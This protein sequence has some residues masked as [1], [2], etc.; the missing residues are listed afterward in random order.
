MPNYQ[1]A[2]IYK[3]TSKQTHKVYVGST[4]QPLQIRLLGHKA[5]Y[6]RYLFKQRYRTTSC[7][8]IIYDDCIIE[9]IENYPCNNKKE[10]SLREGYY[11]LNTEHT[12]NKQVAGQTKQEYNERNKDKIKE[13][14]KVYYYSEKNTIKR[15][16]YYQK[17]KEKNQIKQREYQIKN[18]LD[19]NTS[20]RLR[21]VYQ[22]TF[23]GRTDKD[24]NNSLLKISMDLFK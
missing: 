20:V 4:V 11:I 21:R 15:K 3:I 8:I 22:K 18:R 13:R 14:I 9:L 10:L 24:D 7:E 2:K 19:I 5:D 17:N 23:G 1:L 16:E 6:R 12:V